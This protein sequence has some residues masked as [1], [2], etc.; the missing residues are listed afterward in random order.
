LVG[1]ILVVPALLGELQ[2]RRRVRE[3][4]WSQRPDPGLAPEAVP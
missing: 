3:Q 2:R 4:L 1:P